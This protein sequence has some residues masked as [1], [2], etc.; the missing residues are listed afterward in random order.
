MW[1]YCGKKRLASVFDT[2]VFFK[3]LSTVERGDGDVV[4]DLTEQRSTRFLGLRFCK[5]SIESHDHIHVSEYVSSD[6]RDGIM[7]SFITAC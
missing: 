5:H 7:Q 6:T 3:R 4:D 1:P 2:P